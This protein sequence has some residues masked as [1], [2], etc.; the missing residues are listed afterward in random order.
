ME[1]IAWE[2]SQEEVHRSQMHRYL[3]HVQKTYDAGI[4]NYED[5][6]RWSVQSAEVFWQDLI[7]F[8]DVIVVGEEGPSLEREGWG[9]YGWFPGLRL[10]FAENLL[11][12][13]NPSHPALTFVHESGHRKQITYDTLRFSVQKMQSALKGIIGE[14]D[15]LAAY[16]PNTPETVISMLACTSLGGIFTSTSCDFGVESVIDRFGQ[17]NPQVLVTVGAYQYNG[18]RFDQREKIVSL[19]EKLPGLKKV[20]VV[21]FLNENMALP[22]IPN[23]VDWKDFLSC[24]PLPL[25]FNRVPFSAPLLIMYSSG[26]TGKPKAILHGTGGVLLQ[27]LKELVLHTDLGHKDNIFYFTTCGWM[28]W[29][30]LVSSLA[31]GANIILYEGSPSHPSVK[32]FPAMIER[33]DIVHWGTSPKFLRILEDS[34]YDKNYPL[35]PLKTILSTGAPLLPEQFDFIHKKIK[36]NVRTSSIC[37]GT[38]IVGCFM[39]GNPILPV[40][41]GEISCLGLGMDVAC[42]DSS[43]RAVFNT[44]GEL[45][46]RQSFPS[47]PL[48][49]LNDPDGAKMRKAYFEQFPDVWHHGDF[50]SIDQTGGG[51]QV[52]GRS[53]TTLNPGGIRIGTA[54]IYRQIENIDYLQE[55]V[56][57]GKNNG[58]DVDIVLFVKMSRRRKADFGTDGSHKKNHSQRNR[59]PSRPTIH[60][61]SLRYSLHPLREKNGVARQQN[62]Q[63][64]PTRQPGSGGQPGM[65][66]RISTIC[67]TSDTNLTFPPLP[68]SW[69]CRRNVHGKIRYNRR[70]RFQYRLCRGLQEKKRT[71]FPLAFAVGIVE[72]SGQFLFPGTQNTRGKPF[73]RKWM[74]A[75]RWDKPFPWTD[76]FPTPSCK[77]G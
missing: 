29:N 47:R 1:K 32:D 13:G 34:G 30:W 22:D 71:T 52:F 55:G 27:H 10:N 6:H 48:R 64:S 25:H 14:G 60:P 4:K 54:E 45:V 74:D 19:S 11:T 65:S 18:K 36:D 35:K 21:D 61:P 3:C 69:M 56:C 26:T 9:E 68:P 8:L 38:D 16:M 72:K 70:R 67:L 51:V 31:T 20:V 41:R 12:K 59:P 2:P 58:E 42:Y 77:N 5:M 28:M 53:D 23:V 39:L 40:R 44:E 46:C 33:E 62:C 50:I 15:V 57:V 63:F 75:P 43:G 66:A 24:D 49:F 17:T 7:R 76:W 37:G 73:L